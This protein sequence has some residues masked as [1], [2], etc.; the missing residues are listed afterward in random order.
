VHPAAP[1]RHLRPSTRAGLPV[2]A[3]LQAKD[4]RVASCSSAPSLAAVVTMPV[5]FLAVFIAVCVQAQPQTHSATP[6]P[7]ST[8]SVT[9][10]PRPQPLCDPTVC[11]PF[12]FSPDTLNPQYWDV[13]VLGQSYLWINMWGSAGS[14]SY[15]A[16]VSGVLSVIPGEQ[17]RIIVGAVGGDGKGRSNGIELSGCGGGYY[18]G[19]RSAIQRLSNGMFFDLATAGGGGGGDTGQPYGNGDAGSGLFGNSSIF[20]A[21]GGVS[22][23]SGNCLR[24]KRNCGS[25]IDN[26][27]APPGSWGGG[28]GGWCGGSS[29][30]V[31]MNDQSFYGGGGGS[32]FSANLSCVYLAD[33][34]KGNFFE[35]PLPGNGAGMPRS[36][37]EQGYAG[38][39]SISILP[40]GWQPCAVVLPSSTATASVSPTPTPSSSPS[41]SSSRTPA[42]TPSI[43]GTSS[44]TATSTSSPTA[45]PF[46]TPTPTGVVSPH[47][48]SSSTNFKLLAII[49]WTFAGSLCALF[50]FRH[51]LRSRRA[52]QEKATTFRASG[53]DVEYTAMANLN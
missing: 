53:G 30:T 27:P 26:P 46:P 35:T 48:Q 37:G 40:Q 5:A 36:R 33:N 52:A 23:A 29:I 45:T 42:L 17:L 1:L 20:G 2:Q 12:L 41:V 25:T 11:P 18:G 19:G 50:L 39:V 32:S 6:S 14:G 15:G 28:G 16:F 43:T 9:P 8:P 51:V 47:S 38:A 31:F 7:A 34:M 22:D 10:S 44:L 3:S 4:L 49:G 21:F 13:P 24:G